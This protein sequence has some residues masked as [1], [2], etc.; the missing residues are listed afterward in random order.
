MYSACGLVRRRTG[1]ARSAASA[2]AR[3]PRCTRSGSS[4]RRIARSQHPGEVAVTEEADLAELGEAEPDPHTATPGASRQQ[5]RPGPAPARR[6]GRLP[7]PWLPPAGRRG[8]GDDVLDRVAG[9]GAAVVARRPAA[10][11]EARPRRARRASPARGSPCAGRPRGDPTAAPRPRCGAGTRTSR[12]RG[13]WRPS[14][15]SRGR[16]RSTPTTP[17][18]CRPGATPPRSPRRCG[19]RRGWRCPSATGGLGIVPLEVDA[20]LAAGRVAQQ[21]DLALQLGAWCSGRTTGTA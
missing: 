18:T 6:R 14:P 16:G 3:T 19:D 5:A 10:V 1:P 2:A 12:C 11:L 8:R 4:A 15:R 17:G 20:A 7:V 9:A 21:V 13:R